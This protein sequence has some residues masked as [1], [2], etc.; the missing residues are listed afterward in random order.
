MLFSNLR[1]QCFFKRTVN[2]R[3][4][5]KLRRNIHIFFPLRHLR[6]LF[7]FINKLLNVSSIRVHVSRKKQNLEV[8]FRGLLCNSFTGL[9][10]LRSN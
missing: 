6:L 2:C 4:V 5:E 9:A 3:N 1:Q 7:C 8:I 10:H